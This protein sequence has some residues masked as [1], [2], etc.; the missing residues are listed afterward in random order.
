MERLLATDLDEVPRDGLSAFFLSNMAEWGLFRK[1]GSCRC[2]YS[3]VNSLVGADTSGFESL[4]TQ[5][6]ILVGNEM[7]A[8]RELI[9]VCALAAKVENANLSVGHTSVEARLAIWSQSV[10]L[11]ELVRVRRP[12]G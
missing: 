2:L 11:R 5:L 1:V 7:D 12:Y 9:D 10:F 3:K 8:E 4:G 6:L